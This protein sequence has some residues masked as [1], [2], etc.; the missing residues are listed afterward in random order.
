MKINIA[1]P[2]TGAQKTINI[3]DERRFRIFFDK[4]ISQEVEADILGDEW[5]GYIFR[6]TGGNDKQG[7]PMMQGVLLP[8]RVRLLLT[9]N[10]SCYRASRAGERKRKSVRGCIVGPDIA[11]LSVVIV[12]QGDNDIPGLTDTVLPKRLGPKR[13]TKIRRFFN[14][15]KEDD[16][17]KYVVR[18]EVKSSKKENAKPYTKAPKIQRLVTPIR[19]QRARH[20]RSLNRRRIDR[21]KEQKAEYDALIQKRVAEKKAKVAA[22][23]ASHHKTA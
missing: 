21:Q 17:R 10:H 15:S 3:D 13:A 2:A 19:L 1:N 7:F 5:K 22:I 14:L 20:L 11:V 12:K 6:I 23:K 4:K 9:D 8:Y 18:R 16:V